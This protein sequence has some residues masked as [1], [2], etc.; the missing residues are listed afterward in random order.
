MAF[1][2]YL[3][4]E[5]GKGREHGTSTNAVTIIGANGSGKSKLRAWIE[6]QSMQDMCRIGA[7]RK[8][9]TKQWQSMVEKQ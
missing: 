7:Q 9:S 5:N 2:Y 3:P 1:I 4:D 6:Q 8:Y